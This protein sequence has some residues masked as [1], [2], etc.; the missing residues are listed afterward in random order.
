MINFHCPRNFL[1]SMFVL[2]T[3]SCKERAAVRVLAVDRQCIYDRLWLDG[4]FVII[5]NKN[6]M[7]SLYFV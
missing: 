6:S 5:E 3:V 1:F 7:I 2:V 4:Y